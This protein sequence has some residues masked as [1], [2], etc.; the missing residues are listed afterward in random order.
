MN[1]PARAFGFVTSFGMAPPDFTAETL[2]NFAAVPSDLV[3]DWGRTGSATAFTGLTATST[4]LQLSLANVGNLHVIKL[5]PELIDLTKLA[6]PPGIVAGTA[7]GTGMG[8]SVMGQPGMGQ[9]GM[10]QTFAIGHAGKFK[11]DNFNTFGA[12]VT[13]LAADLAGA[14]MPTVVAIAATGQYDAG[15]NVFTAQRLVVLLSN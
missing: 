10:G 14:G 2:E 6:T 8:Q 12:F 3:V 7:M 1:A 13:Q 9:P 15:T 11:T 5:G 4:S